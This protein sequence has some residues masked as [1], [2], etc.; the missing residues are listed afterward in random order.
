MTKRSRVDDL[1]DR[2][3]FT[4]ESIADCERKIAYYNTLLRRRRKH[5]KYLNKQIEKALERKTVGPEK[6]TRIVEA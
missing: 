5:L 3:N 6:P 1:R 4:E 2:R